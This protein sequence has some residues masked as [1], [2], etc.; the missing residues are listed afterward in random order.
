M[1]EHLKVSISGI[2]GIVGEADGLTAELVTNFSQAFGTALGGGRVLVGSDTRPTLKLVKH[3]IASGLMATGCTMLDG[4]VMPTPAVLHLVR[5]LKADA[6]IIITAS[7]NPIQ[8]NA[9][10]LVNRK[11]LFLGQEEMDRVV[12]LFE[13]KRFVLKGWDGIG[14]SEVLDNAGLLDAYMAHILKFVDVKKIRAQKFRVAVDPVNGAGAGLTKRFLGLLGCTVAAI[15]DTPDGMFGRGAEPVPANLKDLGALVRKKKADVGF[16]QDP[17]AD[18]LAVVSEKGVPLG[19]E[20][21]L[22]MV[23]DAV[24]ERKK[25]TVVINAATSLAS[26]RTALRH[27]CRVVQTRIGEINVT[28]AMLKLGAV[29]GGE[30]NGGVIYPAVNP[31]RD[32]YIGMALVLERMARTGKTPSELKKDLPQFVII[33]E[34]MPARGVDLGS[35]KAKIAAAFRGARTNAIDGLKVVFDDAW[36]IVRPSNTEPIIRLIAEA[37]TETAA[38]ELIGRTRQALK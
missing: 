17:D 18:R 22:A 5:K 35:V 6:G 28:T 2:R 26:E 31:G 33:K 14:G 23:I 12:G 8:W 11:G 30:G 3:A 27:G 24:L 10:K 16:A 20:Y 37:Q 29:I 1:G 25:G 34:S 9:L 21:T 38:R 19:E 4:G 7:H 36:I 32:S 13:K 15:N